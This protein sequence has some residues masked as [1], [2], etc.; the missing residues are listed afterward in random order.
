MD[1]N[2]DDETSLDLLSLSPTSG[3][4]IDDSTEAAFEAIKPSPPK[5]EEEK[6]MKGSKIHDLY[7]IVD[8]KDGDTWGGRRTGYQFF[9]LGRWKVMTITST[10]NAAASAAKPQES[11]STSSS[12]LSS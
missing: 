9:W 8:N 11:V 3:I 2:D 6:L 10:G 1:C 5:E 7:I 4:S 12:S